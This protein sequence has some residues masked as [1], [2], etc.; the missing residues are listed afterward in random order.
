[1]Q[2]D[3]NSFISETTVKPTL[4]NTVDMLLSNPDYTAQLAIDDDKA[5][6]P[7]LHLLL[8]EIEP[9]AWNLASKI[10]KLSPVGQ[11]GAALAV[12][13]SESRLGTDRRAFDPEWTDAGWMQINRFWHEER[14]PST[15]FN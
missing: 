7:N 8:P 14:A 12:S 1:M 4:P 2:S 15:G 10:G 5:F 11:R 13:W 9:F 6:C 3:H